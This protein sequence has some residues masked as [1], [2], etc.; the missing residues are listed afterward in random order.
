MEDS[1]ALIDTDRALQ[2][3]LA[4]LKE[5]AKSLPTVRALVGKILSQPN[6][7]C[8]YDQIKA[9]LLQDVS[10]GDATILGTLDLFSYG[11]YGTYASNQS[12]FLPLNEKQV[13]KLRQLT[14]LS[15]VHAACENGAT[16]LSYTTIEEALQISDQRAMEQVIIS[17][18]FERALNGMLCQKS[19]QLLLVDVPVCISRDVAIEK[20]PLLLHNLRS[21]Q[22][23]LSSSFG[24]LEVAHKE[25]LHALQKSSEYWKLVQARE[26]KAK[27]QSTKAPMAAG[28]RADGAT[29]ALRAGTSRQ[30]NKRTR[31]GL[32]GSYTDPFQR[33]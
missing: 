6:I 26:Q 32:G 1:P 25:V 22:G 30:S 28:V 11:T 2:P 18:I 4:A 12:S 33:Y 16:S 20:L 14:L 17:C 3:H 7:F 9:L 21:L 19:R 13:A 8:G 31:G 5:S 29:G 24:G 10:I 27:Q 23:R 15:C